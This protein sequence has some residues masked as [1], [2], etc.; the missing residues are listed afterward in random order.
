MIG[1]L[2]QIEAVRALNGSVPRCPDYRVS[3]VLPSDLI[4]ENEDYFSCRNKFE[5]KDNEEDEHC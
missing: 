2:S 4:D 3:T 5:V 1:T